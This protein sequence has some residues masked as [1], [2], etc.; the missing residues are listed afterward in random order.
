MTVRIPKD[1]FLGI[2]GWMAFNMIWLQYFQTVLDEHMERWCDKHDIDTFEQL[3][4]RFGPL[5]SE[6]H[7]LISA[8]GID[9]V[10]HWFDTEIDAPDLA[11]VFETKARH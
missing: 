5:P 1:V 2:S 6:V 11:S 9:H 4:R 10:E 8:A 7:K 3:A